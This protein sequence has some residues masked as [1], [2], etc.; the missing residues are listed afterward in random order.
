MTSGA[1]EEDDAELFRRALKD[2]EPL[3]NK[4]PVPKSSA[5]MTK[6]APGKPAKKAR[7]RP[8]VAPRPAPARPAPP[9]EIAAGEFAGVDRRTADRFRRG[10]LPI[11]GHLDLHGHYQDAAHAALTDFIASSAASGRR[12]L[13]VITGRGSREGSGVLRERL[14]GWLNQPP[15]RA[16]VLA[17]TR[18]QPQHGGDGAFYVLLRRK[19]DGKGGGRS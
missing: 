2:A 13:L 6:P 19:R 5:P 3:K 15:C 17:F 12:M 11:D 1:P 16:H 18:A 10:K 14:P 8:P 9:P 4:K 7:A